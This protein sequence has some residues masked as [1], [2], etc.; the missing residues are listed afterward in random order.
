M[1]LPKASYLTTDFFRRFGGYGQKFPL[2]TNSQRE[3]K[4]YS[5][6]KLIFFSLE[7]ISSLS[8]VFGSFLAPSCK[9]FAKK[10]PPS[11]GSRWEFDFV[12]PFQKFFFYWP[13]EMKLNFGR[14]FSKFP[15]TSLLGTKSQF[16]PK[17]FWRSSKISIRQLM[18]TPLWSTTPKT[19]LTWQRTFSK[20]FFSMRLKFS[21]YFLCR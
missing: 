13:M 18:R 9:R 10:F 12:H 20:G 15:S 5:L 1:H 21:S 19:P 2:S 8:A 17:V 16:C 6:S 7:N 14:S 3:G 11:G 4:F